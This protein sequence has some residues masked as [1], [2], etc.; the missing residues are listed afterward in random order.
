MSIPGFFEYVKSEYRLPDYAN[1]ISARA[2][3]MIV[4]LTAQNTTLMFSVSVAVQGRLQGKIGHIFS[5][6]GQ[7][8][9]NFNS[10]VMQTIHDVLLIDPQFSD[11]C[12]IK[13]TT[14]TFKIS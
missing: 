8:E 7:N 14:C 1:P 5:K 3:C 2:F 4:S 12:G 13:V 6:W 10:S 11:Q 9:I